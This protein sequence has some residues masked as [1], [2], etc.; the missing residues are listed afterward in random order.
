[1]K[2]LR[3]LILIFFFLFNSCQKT[4]IKIESEST[5]PLE[6]AEIILSEII[7][8]QQDIKTVRL[9]TNAG[10]DSKKKRFFFR[11]FIKG[12]KPSFIYMTS[13]K[14]SNP[15]LSLSA[16]RNNVYAYD[17]TVDRYY[18][19]KQIESVTRKITGIGLKFEDLLS[20]SCGGIFIPSDYIIKESALINNKYLRLLIESADRAFEKREI[21]AD[22]ST[23]TPVFAKIFYDLESV[24]IIYEKYKKIKAIYFP[25]KITIKKQKP[26]LKITL[27]VKGLRINDSYADSDF[28][29]IIPPEIEP[30]P[31]NELSDFF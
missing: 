2:N 14:F 5:F 30:T 3:N 26:Y 1:M 18:S 29:L 31:L 28:K 7:K 23:K 19:G 8:N 21:F 10:I 4:G 24:E 11:H 25:Y 15:V 22:I 27:K 17:Y 13:M 9:K 12:K 20:L 6:K 16:D